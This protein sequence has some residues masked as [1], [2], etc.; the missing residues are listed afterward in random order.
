MATCKSQEK[1]PHF[2]SLLCINSCICSHVCQCI[3]NNK[4]SSEFACSHWDINPHP[5]LIKDEKFI[6]N[7]LPAW[8]ESNGRLV[9]PILTAYDNS[10]YQLSSK[11]R[12]ELQSWDSMPKNSTYHDYWDLKGVK[13]TRELERFDHIWSCNYV[14]ED[15]YYSSSMGSDTFGSFIET[16]IMVLIKMIDMELLN[17][18]GRN[19]GEAS[20]TIGKKLKFR[21]ESEEHIVMHDSKRRLFIDW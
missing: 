1:C 18:G 15:V 12:V 4:F 14:V 19:A 17:A 10:E 5:E 21:E 16:K 9:G 11:N 13:F 3:T 8:G 6:I 20:P 2:N 7:G